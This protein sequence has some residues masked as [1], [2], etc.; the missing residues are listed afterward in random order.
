MSVFDAYQEEYTSKLGE[1]RALIR[2]LSN[3]TDTSRKST[4]IANI[5]QEVNNLADQLKQ[6]DIEVRTSSPAEKKALMEKQTKNKDDLNSCRSEFTN[7]KFDSQKAALT[8]KSGEDKMR[9]VD[10]NQK[11]L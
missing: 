9:Y 7:A 11:Y 3:T 6:M 8:G 4:L 10:V 1:T 2:E 5:E